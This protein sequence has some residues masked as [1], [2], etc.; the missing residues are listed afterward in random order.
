M[1]CG[2]LA[3]LNRVV[4]ARCVCVCVYVCVCVC[5]TI[6]VQAGKQAACT[7]KDIQPPCL[8]VCFHHDGALLQGA[9]CRR[10]VSLLDDSHVDTRARTLAHCA[11]P[12]IFADYGLSGIAGGGAGHVCV[13]GG[14][15]KSIGV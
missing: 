3:G 15:C 9:D 2:G 10:D 13:K 7:Y 5:T 8:E 14:T 6:V 12:G 1:V 11:A 4:D